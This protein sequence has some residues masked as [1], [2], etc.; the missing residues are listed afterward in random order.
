MNGC[1]KLIIKYSN[2]LFKFDF[3]RG[4]LTIENAVEFYSDLDIYK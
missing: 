4:N 1:L 3:T 2:I